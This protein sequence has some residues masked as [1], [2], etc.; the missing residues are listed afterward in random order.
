MENI[1]IEALRST[2]RSTVGD[3]A[4]PVLF[5][6]AAIAQRTWR[7]S[8]VELAHA[9]IGR[10]RISDGEMFAANVVMFRIVRDHLRMPGSKWS[11]L[12]SEFMRTGRTVAD[13][14]GTPHDPGP[15]SSPACP[16][17]VRRSR[18]GTD[19]TTLI[20]MNAALALVGVRDTVWGMPRW[21]AVVEAFIN[22][23]DSTPAR[24][25]GP[26]PLLARW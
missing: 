26:N 7:N 16:T 12:E 10:N 8:E 20:A 11:E 24:P 17:P 19:A 25:V 5:A 21:P 14:L 15:T 3:E 13:H 22:D 23:L 6:A 1:H 4:D 9:G 2:F 18:A